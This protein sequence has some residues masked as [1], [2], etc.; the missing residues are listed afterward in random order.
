M[1]KPKIIKITEFKAFLGK[2]PD[3]VADSD[4]MGSP[5]KIE[6][7]ITEDRKKSLHKAVVKIQTEGVAAYDFA[8][9]TVAEA[10][11]DCFLQYRNSS[12]RV[13]NLPAIPSTIRKML[14]FLVYSRYVIEFGFNRNKKEVKRAGFNK[15]VI[16]GINREVV[17]FNQ[18]NNSKVSIPACAFT[19]WNINPYID[20]KTVRA[21]T[22]PII[23][24]DYAG[25]KH[26]EYGFS[27]NH[28]IE[29]LWNGEDTRFDVF[30]DVFGGSGQ[31]FMNA[32]PKE[33]VREYI[34]DYDILNY[35]FYRV[36]SSRCEK[37]ISLCEEV[38]GCLGKSDTKPFYRKIRLEGR[39][40]IK[41][42]KTNRINSKPPKSP[43]SEADSVLD[44]KGEEYETKVTAGSLEYAA[45]LWRR[46]NNISKKITE[47]KD[48]PNDVLYKTIQK[49]T[50]EEPLKYRLFKDTVDGEMTVAFA[51]YYLQYFMF[52]GKSKTITAVNRAKIRK[53]VKEDFR[54]S[55]EPFGKRIK[56]IRRIK[57]HSG[58]LNESAMDLLTD[59]RLNSPKSLVYM[60]SPYVAT[61]GYN[62]PF[63][64]YSMRELVKSIKA[65]QGKWI[66]SCRAAVYAQ[67]KT[68]KL[69]AKKRI[70]IRAKRDEIALL[71]A[72][73]LSDD[74]EI[75]LKGDKPQT[76]AAFKTV[77]EHRYDF[78][79]NNGLS[80]F[81]RANR[82]ADGYHVL[83]R[84]AI[85]NK[86]DV[87]IKKKFAWWE[88]SFGKV[89]M[90]DSR[91]R[92]YFNNYIW[93]ATRKLLAERIKSIIL[94]NRI[95]EIMITNFHF[96]PPNY[97]HYRA[98]KGFVSYRYT[99]D[100]D[101]E[102]HKLSFQEFCRIVMPILSDKVKP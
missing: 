3:G 96:V 7:F 101:N 87:C 67:S 76:R 47:L 6:R 74:P 54:S 9:K 51:F 62:V 20:F 89:N 2:L 83:F 71:F 1:A 57:G 5:C 68:K 48:N 15:E 28:L 60:D 77:N 44:E 11:C 94:N 92:M 100:Y 69:T 58:I 31:G 19:N 49:L 81:I 82:S 39:E 52:N 8:Y 85:K 61:I 36:V 86:L 37:F 78:F 41:K 72:M 63:D 95:F 46:A 59:P 26:N 32:E 88:E 25:K 55:L 79:K 64:M 40:E 99:N 30:A 84:A 80:E 70:D 21:Y 33:G 22:S 90:E 97:N 16:D 98:V 45:G 75:V 13:V 53:F 27:I 24:V 29:F 43:I 10:L 42:R 34:N 65:Y 102:W 73:M 14:Y 50:E 12:P 66:F 38:V 23:N 17:A 56:A 91:T 18:A 4:R 35:T 93:T